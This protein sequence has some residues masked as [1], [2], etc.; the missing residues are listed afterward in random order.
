MQKTVLF[1]GL[2][3]IEII[4]IQ[5]QTLKTSVDLAWPRCTQIVPYGPIGGCEA[6]EPWGHAILGPWR[7]AGCHRW[8]SGAIHGPH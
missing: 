4:H 7:A 2:T 5:Y 1:E 8:P 3:N 6:M